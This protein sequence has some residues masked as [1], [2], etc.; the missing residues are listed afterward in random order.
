MRELPTSPV[1]PLTPHPS[2]RLARF[3]GVLPIL[4]IAVL[5]GIAVLPA[6]T[7]GQ[8]RTAPDELEARLPQA[9]GVDRVRLLAELTEAYR[10]TAPA[11]AVDFAESALAL[12]TAY[13][14]PVSE[15]R[16][17]NEMA[18]ALMELGQY[19]AAAGRAE[20]GLGRARAG[21]LRRHEARAMNN[22]GVIARR[23]GDFPKALDCFLQ[24]LEIYRDIGDE[25]AV[26]TSLNNLSVVM[27]F[28][29][30]DYQRAVEHQLQALA[31]RERLGDEEGRYQ[32]YNSLGV[33]YGNLGDQG[34]AIR[35]LNQ[36][37][38]GWQAL[39]LRPRIAA[40]L[41]NL[42]A[43]YARSGQLDRAL[44]AQRESLSLRT[45]LGNLSG[46]AGS[47]S[48]IGDILSQLGRVA[49]ARP[50][51]ER[52]LAMRREM[53]ERKT[54][55]QSLIA[56]A[57]LERRIGRLSEA[58]QNLEGAMALATEISAPEE[59][60]DAYRE[61]SSVREAR[62][63]FRG[64]VAALKTWSQINADLFSEERA[65][66]IEALETEF[67]YTRARQE[68]ERLRG[69][70][71]LS[72]SLAQQRRTQMLVAILIGLVAFLLYR[73]HVTA[74]VRRDLARLVQERTAELS[75]ANARLKALSLTDTLTGIPNRR[76]FFQS[77]ESDVAVSLRA[78]RMPLKEGS[79]LENG[80]LV[81]Y[82]LDLDDFKSVNDTYG[83][84]AGDMVLQQVGAVLRETGRASDLVVRWGGE[85]FLVVARQVDR[86][87]AAAFAERIRQAVRNHMFAAGDGRMLHRTC[88]VG[89]AAFPF[90]LHD[91]EAVPWD[92]V[93]GI[94]DQAAYA[95]KQAGR[96]AWVGVI[97]N[98]STVP[99]DVSAAREVVGRL[100]AAGA[101]TV[102]SSVVDAGSPSLWGEA[103]L[104][105]QAG[106]RD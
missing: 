53:G 69:D 46:V 11:R 90:L 105:A 23:T 94:A 25:V 102:V 27:G 65:R 30:G 49:E 54:E 18:W 84:A 34:E 10:S 72:A 60:R 86:R 67:R 87:G 42:S 76:Y 58:Q 29:V 4:A 106:G 55:A 85:E 45:A 66:R 50:P 44:A 28:D 7:S 63:D 19:A 40:T 9:T 24:A 96:D 14:D 99:S 56:L 17:L 70:A 98:E 100:A 8:G 1:L 35:Y 80:D 13:P 37:L 64:A 104:A 26:A 52:A 6:A 36:A 103:S 59:R 33:I 79:P 93:L 51:L 73:R 78:H 3:P 16:A 2:S 97:G 57:R 15:V 91:I 20:E 32:S 71:Q 39:D 92:T 31:I 95:S 101:L 82:V 5:A 75:D 22:L 48:S 81:F 77:V 38:E 62:G 41:D 61:L 12:A 47:L 74:Q 21:L 83:H 89:F 88:S 68:I 43:V